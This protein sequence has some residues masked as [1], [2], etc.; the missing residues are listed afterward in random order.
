MTLSNESKKEA[1]I[2]LRKAVIIGHRRRKDLCTVCGK[3]PHAGDCIENYI[4]VDMRETTEIKQE[5]DLLKQKN[6][7]INYRKK[8][9]LCLRCGK[10]QHNG[11]CD[12]SYEKVDNRTEVEKIERPAIISAPKFKPVTILEE[13]K[14]LQAKEIK[15]QL[16]KTKN[17]KLQRDFIVLSI[18]PSMDGNIVEFSCLQH[19]SRRYKN[20]IVCIIGDLEKTYTYSDMLK[21]KKLTNI[22][23]IKGDIQ[24][25]INHLFSCKMLL[26]FENDYTDYCQKNSIPVY[27]FEK[28][29]N[30][31]SILKRTAFL[32]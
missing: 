10:E 22:H 26:S 32:D 14:T 3:S 1:G 28:G 6:S 8:K 27:I 25:V 16:K 29:K 15:I 7:I 13:I 18:L 4:K 12:E 23:Q 20:L 24:D 17:I 30:A 5:L 2:R 9:I 31:N 19:L 21:I 11:C